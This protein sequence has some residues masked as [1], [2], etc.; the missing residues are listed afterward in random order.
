MPRSSEVTIQVPSP[1]QG[2]L[3]FSFLEVTEVTT[4]AVVVVYEGGGMMRGGVPIESWSPTGQ[5]VFFSALGGFILTK[6]V[7]ALVA[8]S[9]VDAINRKNADANVSLVVNDREV[10]VSLAFSL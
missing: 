10:G 2:G 4:A 3:A 8:A 1:V 7:D 5:V 6:F 9:T